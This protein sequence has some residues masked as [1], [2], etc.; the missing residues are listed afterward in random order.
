M[1]DEFYLQD[2]RSYVGN[3][4]AFWAKAGGYTTDVSKAEVFT[5][6]RAVSQHQ[7]RETDIP[8]PKAYI[9][10]RTRPAVDFQYCKRAEALQGTGIQLIKPK[11]PRRYDC[12]CTG[13]GRFIS[14]RRRFDPCPNCG[15][16]NRP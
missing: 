8:W 9:D 10:A 1:G 7:M 3:D 5:K 11:P 13:C 12:N 14:E 4:M 6:E 15:A 2:S 16:D